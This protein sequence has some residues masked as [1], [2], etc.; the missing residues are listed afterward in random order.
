MTSVQRLTF[1]RKLIPGLAYNHV[2]FFEND[3]SPYRLSSLRIPEGSGWV[4]SCIDDSAAA[5]L[6]YSAEHKELQPGSGLFV[7]W[8]GPGEGRTV[9]VDV[10]SG[11]ATCQASCQLFR[12]FEAS[13]PHL[14]VCPAISPLLS[15]LHF[16]SFAG[17]EERGVEGAGGEDPGLAAEGDRPEGLLRPL[18]L[19]P[20]PSMDPSLLGPLFHL[21]FHSSFSN[22]WRFVFFVLKDALLS[23]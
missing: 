15:S 2:T 17:G 13:C 7:V 12:A 1:H 9:S 21:A 5:M 16:S 3:K 19:R 23:Y 18:R 10:Q 20:S 8:E 22:C 11:K 6:G 14:E 4:A